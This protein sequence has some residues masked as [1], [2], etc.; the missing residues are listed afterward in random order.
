MEM[1]QPVAQ[2]T[3]IRKER[4]IDPPLPT[5][6]SAMPEWMRGLR[7]SS[8]A[9]CRAASIVEHEIN[10]PAQAERCPQEVE[11]QGLLHIEQGE[12]HEDGERD[13]LLEDLELAQLELRIADAVRGHLQEILEESDTPTG[14]RRHNPGLLV[15]LLQMRVP[16]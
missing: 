8:V 10:G 11:L 15:E 5:A 6:Q 3:P 2:A 16:G 12:R 13:G 7:T 1:A 9:P 14:E 4:R